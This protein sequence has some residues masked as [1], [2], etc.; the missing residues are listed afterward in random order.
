VQYYVGQVGADS[1]VI[2]DVDG[3]LTAVDTQVVHLVG[4]G[5]DGIAFGD[6]SA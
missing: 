2:Y 4:V 6:I 3:A 5:L 1:Y